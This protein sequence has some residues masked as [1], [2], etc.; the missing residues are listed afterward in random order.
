MPESKKCRICQL[1]KPVTEFSRS[2]RGK[3]SA[4]CKECA[5]RLQREWY[6]ENKGDVQIQRS[7]ATLTDALNKLRRKAKDKGL[8]VKVTFTDQF[9]ITVEPQ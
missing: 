7:V 1:V 6:N 5:A 9:V 2:N 8:D 3:V 4:R